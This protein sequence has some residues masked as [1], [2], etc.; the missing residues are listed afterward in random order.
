M[1]MSSVQS[2]SPVSLSGVRLAVKLT[3]QGPA[4]AVF[5]AAVWPIQGPDG[6]GAG[7]STKSD[8]WPVNARVTSGSGPLGP[9]FQGVW[10]SLQPIVFT[11]WAPRSMRAFVFS[12][13]R[14]PSW[15]DMA[16]S[17]APENT[18][19]ASTVTVVVACVRFMPE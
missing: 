6:G 9:I 1:N 19:I 12:G 7:G 13:V 8:G 11:R 4:N 14:A 5:V 17:S 10:Q 18:A 16:P 2:P 15:A 3:P